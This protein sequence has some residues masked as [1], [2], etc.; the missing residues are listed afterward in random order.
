MLLIYR[1]LTNLLFPV[2]IILVYFRIFLNKEDKFRFKE[3]IFPSFFYSNKNPKKKLIWFHAASIGEVSSIIS[4]IKKLN[5]DDINFLITSVTLTSGKLI[6]KELGS[7]QNLIHKYFPLDCYFLVNKFL[8]LAKPDIA[9]FVDSE[10]WPN[11]LFE[12]KKRKIPLVLINGRINKKTLNKWRIFPKI[13]ESIF[14]NFDLCLPSSR[15]S[16]NNLRLLGA[17]NIKYIGNLKFNTSF[18]SKRLD[19]EN[20]NFLNSHKVWFASSTH[21]GEEIFCLNVHVKVKKI[22]NSLITIIAPRH[23]SR[24]IEIENLSKTLNLK[25]QIL[26]DGEKIIK[27]KEI[28]II[29][30]FG[31]LSKYFDYCKSVFVGK[32][33]LKKL[34]AVGGQNPIEAAKCGCKVY[35]GPYVYNFNEVYE[36]LNS[37]GITEI[38]E[39]DKKLADKLIEDFKDTKIID[40]NKVNKIDVYGEKILS[41]TI[42]EL[43]QFI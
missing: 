36:Y 38:I 26:N 14:K 19:I 41:D 3:K 39:T 1:Y 16:E 8:S 12:I 2:L 11:F 32:S 15:E 21:K 28:I 27:N 10:I 20:K 13:S 5:T 33:I 43:K 17:K 30:S 9:M 29:N 34:E 23:I 6:E 37:L 7:N 31:V 40:E 18:I 42:V 35:H 24:I 25:T 4:L 22:Y